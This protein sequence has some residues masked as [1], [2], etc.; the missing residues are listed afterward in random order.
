MSHHRLSILVE[1]G[2]RSSRSMSPPASAESART[3]VGMAHNSSKIFT[4][5]DGEP[6]FLQSDTGAWDCN[7]GWLAGGYGR[8]TVQPE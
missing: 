6:G 4:E 8:H 2:G 1:T 3:R 7:Q 5:R